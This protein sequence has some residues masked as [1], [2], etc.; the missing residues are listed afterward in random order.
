MPLS[1]TAIRNAKPHQKPYKLVDE[2]GMYLLVNHAGRYFRM[3][4]RHEGKRKTLA[5]GVYPETTL[6][7]AREKRDAAR[8][9]LEKG[10]DPSLARKVE[11]I[12][13]AKNTFETVAREWHE[14]FR[15]TWTDGHAITLMSRLERDLFPWL[16]NRPVGDIK[17]PELLRV[18]SRVEDRGALETAHRI[19]TIAGQ[20]FRYAIQT[21]RAERDP[22]Q[23]LK[24]ALPPTEKK[25][26][27]ATTD[28]AKLG[29][30]LS[31]LEGYQGD[32]ITRCAL[33]LLPL[34]LCRPGELRHMEWSELDLDAAEWNI[35]AEKMKMRQPHLVPL[36]RQ[37]V[38]ILLEIKPLTGAG[39]Y[40]FP[41]ARSTVRPM[42]NNTVNA[43]M[44]RMGID[45]RTEQTGHGFRAVARTILDEVLRV[46]PEYIEHQLAHAVRDPL[47]RAYNRTMHLSER[48]AMMQR[49][50]DYLDMLRKGVSEKVVL[51]RHVG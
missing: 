41:S 30:L 14:R 37:A 28:P 51:F 4:Y 48:R 31:I 36:P 21:G 18:L 10:I 25:H 29:G 44:R 3:D 1:D 45:T 15:H 7:G 12:T 13:G 50:S 16:G 42:S 46:R 47:G 49:W 24:G 6:A 26:M 40:V 19:R 9:Q 38:D 39:R 8:K 35:P 33:R 2:K 34:L 20:V 27:A 43:A 11:K 23:D 17:A 22:S 5:L 32:I